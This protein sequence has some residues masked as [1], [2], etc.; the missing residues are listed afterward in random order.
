V[1]AEDLL[2]R[3]MERHRT[4]VAWERQEGHY[5]T[6]NMH[7]GRIFV[8]WV[9]LLAR[10]ACQQ[11]VRSGGGKTSASRSHKHAAQKQITTLSSKTRVDPH[12]PPHRSWIPTDRPKPL[13]VVFLAHGVNEHIG[14]YTELAHALTKEGYAGESESSRAVESI[15]RSILVYDRSDPTALDTT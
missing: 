15:D 6:S 11:S 2:G 5:V 3:A 4:E 8:R 1:E 13:A 7:G 9:V 12:A 14:R 10:V